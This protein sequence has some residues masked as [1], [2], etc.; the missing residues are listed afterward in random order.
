MKEKID[1]GQAMERTCTITGDRKEV[2]RL[3]ETLEA[4][5]SGIE[6]GLSF[7]TIME[8]AKAGLRHS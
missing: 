1:L 2:K 6:E 5:V 4:I 7:K 8:R 3:R